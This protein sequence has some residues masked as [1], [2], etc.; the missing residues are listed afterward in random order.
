MKEQ[1]D[2]L[3]LY[4]EV[5]PVLSAEDFA[6]FEPLQKL[7]TSALEKLKLPLS[8]LLDG[9]EGAEQRVGLLLTLGFIRQV[10][11]P[12]V[13]RYGRPEL[14]IRELKTWSYLHLLAYA[15]DRRVTRAAQA[16]RRLLQRPSALG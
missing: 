15:R 13:A 16:A 11:S 4:S 12:L 10:V 1:I 6:F 7:S 5:D 8:Q 3:N 14:M 2:V 9:V